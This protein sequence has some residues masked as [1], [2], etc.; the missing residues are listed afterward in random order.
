MAKKILFV[1]ANPLSTSRIRI[2]EEMRE[3]K[4]CLARAKDRDNFEIRFDLAAQLSDLRRSLL[5][6]KPQIVHFSGHGTGESGIILEYPDGQARLVSADSLSELFN[7]V[8]GVDC[9]LLNACYTEVQ[10]NELSKHVRYVIGKSDPFEDKA[11]IAFSAAFYEAV[12]SDAPY[13]IAFGFGCHAL[14]SDFPQEAVPLL[15]VNESIEI[16]S[17]SPLYSPTKLV[18]DCLEE[19]FDVVTIRDFCQSYFTGVSKRITPYD[20]LDEIIR[21]IISFY[22]Q[23]SKFEYFWQAIKKERPDLYKKYYSIWKRHNK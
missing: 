20:G 15:G 17:D 5:E 11:A 18:R 22:S 13:E 10:A 8:S 1:A 21:R 16:S 14:T 9:I 19:G 6:F 7:L 23:N 2:D 12:F 4:A 3:L